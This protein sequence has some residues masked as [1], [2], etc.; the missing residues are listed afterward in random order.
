ME[1]PVV[2]GVIE[3]RQRR[4]GDMDLEAGGAE[5]VQEDKAGDDDGEENGE[6][7]LCGTHVVFGFAWPWV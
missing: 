3:L 5:A 7:F 4:V 6:D 2:G 1:L